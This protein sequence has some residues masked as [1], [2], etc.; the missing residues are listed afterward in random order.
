MDER[1]RMQT[2][3]LIRSPTPLCSYLASLTWNCGVVRAKSPGGQVWCPGR[4]GVVLPSRSATHLET[5]A[6]VAETRVAARIEASMAAIFRVLRC[7]RWGR[8]G[9][10]VVWG[11]G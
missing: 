3:E 11:H 8:V 6:R 5:S 2:R 4:H 9:E 7:G 1:A 10:E